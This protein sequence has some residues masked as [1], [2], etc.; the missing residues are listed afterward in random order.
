MSKSTS[1][2]TNSLS[3]TQPMETNVKS[4]IEE[5]FNFAI[6]SVQ[7]FSKRPNDNVL[8][9]FY[10]YYKQATTGKCNIQKPGMFDIKGQ[11]KWNAWNSLGN[12]S[13]NDAMIAYC[14]FYL[15]V[16]DKYN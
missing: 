7:N 13:K 1:A 14:D 15:S 9:I 3:R 16:A 2:V 5:N 4:D 10:K 6:E 8:L 11:A 12:M